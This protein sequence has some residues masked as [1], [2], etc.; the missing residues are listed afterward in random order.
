MKRKHLRY[1]ALF[2]I[3]GFMCLGALF[4]YINLGE[5]RY[6]GAVMVAALESEAKYE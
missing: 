4:Q 2:A 1:A 5:N 3:L 6:A